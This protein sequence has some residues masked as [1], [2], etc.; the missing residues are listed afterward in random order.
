MSVQ[1]LT[2]I[3]IG[4]LSGLKFPNTKGLVASYS[5]CKLKEAEVMLKR[6]LAGYKL[7]LGRDCTSTL[8]TGSNLVNLYRK[9]G[10][11]REAEKK[12]YQREGAGYATIPQRQRAIHLAHTWYI[13]VLL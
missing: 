10:K 4:D 3:S 12:M 8:R 7:A 9:Q 5:Q 6:A 13:N 2:A 1:I 11:L